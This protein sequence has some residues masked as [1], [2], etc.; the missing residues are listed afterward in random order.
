MAQQE[1]A[2]SPVGAF[3]GRILALR[4][5]AGLGQRELAA[6]LGVSTRAVQA[7]EAGVSYPS[8]ASLQRLLALYAEQGTLTAGREAEEAAAVWAAALREA[9]R[10][11]VPFDQAWFAALL[12]IQ[13]ARA[14]GATGA[15]SPG[16][17]APSDGA[18]DDVAPAS[19]PGGPSGAAGRHE[20]WGEAPDAREFVD[21]DEE[22]ATLR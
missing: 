6:R 17:G 19:G 11:Q 10:L 22:L 8:A 21:R 12:A 18:A 7:W 3:R 1:A 9:P 20:D 13:R 5:R 2:D 15:V 14:T 4:G 16:R